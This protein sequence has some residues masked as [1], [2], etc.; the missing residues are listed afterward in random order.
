MQDKS[1]GGGE[2]RGNHSSR[3]KHSP[4]TSST[5]AIL[6][7]EYSYYLPTSVSPLALLL[8]PTPSPLY[9][10]MPPKPTPAV[11]ASSRRAKRIIESVSPSPPERSQSSSLP[12]PSPI[13][14]AQDEIDDED[15]VDISGEEYESEEGAFDQKRSV[16]TFFD[17]IQPAQPD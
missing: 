16:G 12:A 3:R 8:T 4:P 7:T 13:A 17:I 11:T 14:Q 6:L 9:P 1:K 2:S 10:V 5:L 15:G